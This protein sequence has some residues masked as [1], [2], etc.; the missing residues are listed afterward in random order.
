MTH[1]AS[2]LYEE[3]V[4]RRE[5]GEKVETM[6]GVVHGNSKSYWRVGWYGGDGL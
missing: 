5:G 3:I 4:M 1:I 2:Q 6:R